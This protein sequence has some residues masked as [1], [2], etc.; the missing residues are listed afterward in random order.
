MKR[1]ETDMLQPP[2]LR[3]RKRRETLR[4]ITDAG[5]CLFVEKGIDAT[6]LDEIATL[7]GISRR[8]FFHY[9]KSKDDIL[10]SLQNGMGAMIADRIRRASQAVTPLQ[11]IRD[12]V[13]AT[14][15]EVPADDM[16]AIDRLMRS[17]AAVQARKQA[18]YVEHERVLFAA[19]CDRWPDPARAMALRLVA[20]LA[21]GAVRLATE[22]LG[23]DGERRTLVELLD[24]AF[25]ALQSELSG[26]PANG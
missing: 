25:D 21:I 19:L 22:T 7:A 14:C 12:A 26:V 17:S 13:V 23:Q 20:L 11:A 1:I 15:A 5:I 18:S 24:T 3:E 16:I 10:L 8:T 6:T 9:F 4:R 2:G